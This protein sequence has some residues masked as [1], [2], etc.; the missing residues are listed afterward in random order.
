[1][2][3]EDDDDTN[4]MT[5]RAQRAAV[6]HLPKYYGDILRQ[7][8][9]FGQ[10]KKKSRLYT[11]ESLSSHRTTTQPP[12]RPAFY[13]IDLSLTPKLLYTATAFLQLCAACQR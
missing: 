7:R 5:L 9:F 11:V 6:S 3:D 1:M 4:P 2:G 13:S 8:G 12:P 10:T